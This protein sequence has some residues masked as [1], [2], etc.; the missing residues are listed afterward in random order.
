MMTHKTVVCGKLIKRLYCNTAST[1][2]T[3]WQQVKLKYSDKQLSVVL[4]TLSKGNVNTLKKHGISDSQIDQIL[5]PFKETRIAFSSVDELITQDILGVSD[6]DSI[7]SSLTAKKT[8]PKK[9]KANERELQKSIIQDFKQVVG[10]LIRAGDVSWCHLELSEKNCSVRMWECQILSELPLQADFREA[11][12]TGMKIAEALPSVDAYV[13]E[14]E[15]T[16]VGTQS[17]SSMLRLRTRQQQIIST[18]ITCL[19]LRSNNSVPSSGDDL[20]FLHIMKP[21]TTGKLF[22][23]FLNGETVSSNNI[24]E[25]LLQQQD[26]GLK[27]V[28]T[29]LCD[30]NIA[31]KYSSMAQHVKEQMSRS[32]L[33]TMAFLETRGKTNS[34][35]LLCGTLS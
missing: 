30:E 15:S 9:T 22:G 14:K 6:L 16:K 28:P 26:I 8:S 2:L 5:Q 12:K 3:E 19:A 33:L 4:K 27:N 11:I 7:C 20:S 1:K 10:L 21:Y 31:D 23:L 18:V 29:L 17:N 34:K 25:A 24:A 35:K 32:L 13:M